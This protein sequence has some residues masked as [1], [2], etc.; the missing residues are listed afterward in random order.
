MVPD[1]E[2]MHDD[3][4]EALSVVFKVL[5][6]KNNY[7]SVLRHHI[8]SR[9]VSQY[10]G[11]TL[12]LE[13]VCKLDWIGSDDDLLQMACEMPTMLDKHNPHKAHKSHLKS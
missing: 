2:L 12:K 9:K 10:E 1:E 4:F 6:P 5:K 8:K 7:S 13:S 3:T 11:H